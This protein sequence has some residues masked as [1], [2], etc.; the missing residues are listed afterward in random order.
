MAY[1]DLF[2][3]TG[4]YYAKYRPG[5]PKEFFADVIKKFTLDGT[6][7]LF[8]LGC[9]T[10]QLAIPLAPFFK[11]VIAMDPEPE[12]L[13]EGKT[14]AKKAKTRNIQWI[15]GSSENLSPRIG[16]FKL[17]VMGRSFHWMDRNRVLRKLYKMIEPG[18]GIVVV[19][20]HDVIPSTR[21]RWKKAIKKVVQKY[22][23][24]E[25]RAGSG[26]YKRP[27]D[28]HQVVIAS[29]PF[30]KSRIINYKEI[31][32]WTIPQ[33]LGHLY[34]TSFSSRAVLGK[35]RVP[36]E[37]D[38]KQILK[39]INR[40]GHFIERVNVEAIYVRKPKTRDESRRPR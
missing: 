37:K 32:M 30:K 13:Q 18:G 20:E 26:I 14:Q 38:L 31:R 7:R 28:K 16:K 24:E 35:N 39:T 17:V 9:G 2:K 21:I 19:A 12:M 27:K 11:E 29:S 10:G 23:G 36:F 1:R 25:R 34:S 22:L 40:K 6:G 5:Y 3:G 4:K 8:D 33:I 15:R